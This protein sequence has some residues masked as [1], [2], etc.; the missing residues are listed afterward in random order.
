[1]IQQEHTMKYDIGYITKYML[2]YDIGIPL[3]V[4]IFVLLFVCCIVLVLFRV[5]NS[6]SLFVKQASFCLFMGYLFLVL[7]TT[8][9]FREETFVKRYNINPLWSYSSLYNKQLAQI[10]MNVI[11]FIPIGFFAGG[12]LKKKH[13][14]K[15]IEIGIV[16][17]LFIEITQLITTRGVFNVDDIIHNTLGCVIGFSVF[18][19]CYKLIKRTA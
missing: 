9:F 11:M 13:V 18:V 8:I 6:Y 17:S 4:I 15:A 7:C 16:L 1:M 10:I 5:K 19:L 12:A 3:V 14:S 2:D